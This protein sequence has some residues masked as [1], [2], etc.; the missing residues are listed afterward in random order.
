MVLGFSP[1]TNLK[2]VIVCRVSRF[3]L[4]LGRV[5]RSQFK[6][7]S[8]VARILIWSAS[9]VQRPASEATRRPRVHSE[10][11]SRLITPAAKAPPHLHPQLKV[12]VQSRPGRSPNK[13]QTYVRDRFMVTSNR[14]AF[15]SA[16]LWG[17]PQ[18][19]KSR[20]RSIPS[21]LFEYPRRSSPPA[22]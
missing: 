5:L 12:A 19:L 6:S 20:V 10:A 2:E 17:F 1:G 8:L 22:G 16:S 14:P 13:A 18:T 21:N 9:A 3:F 7:T 11:G 15:I 4:R